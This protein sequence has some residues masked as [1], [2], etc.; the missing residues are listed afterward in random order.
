MWGVIGD[1]L[2]SIDDERRHG[3]VEWWWMRCD[4][5]MHVGKKWWGDGEENESDSEDVII[6]K[7]IINGHADECRH[8]CRYEMWWYIETETSMESDTD[9][10]WD[11]ETR[12]DDVWLGTRIQGYGVRMSWLGQGLGV[13]VRVRVLGVWPGEDWRHKVRLEL[14]C[15]MSL[16]CCSPTW[17]LWNNHFSGV[18]PIVGMG[19]CRR[20]PGDL[21]NWKVKIGRCY[22]ASDFCKNLGIGW[23]SR[24][25]GT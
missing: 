21:E 10:G 4:V 11:R 1:P 6:E 19:P 25:L 5:N 13:R 7:H 8:G 9:G 23:R 12:R 14:H 15:H 18:G 24:P 16:I 17:D 3:C 2:H 20:S 22:E